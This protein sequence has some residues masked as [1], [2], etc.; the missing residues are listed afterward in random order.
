MPT[1]G[2]AVRVP[3]G[4]ATFI[5][6]GG[7]DVEIARLPEA[8]ALAPGAKVMIV[9]ENDDELGL[10]I[11]DPENG[12]LRVMATPADGFTAIDG[13]LVGWRVERALALRR[14]LGLPAPDAAYRLV[15]A[16]G[17]GLPGIACDVLGRYA[18]LWA[19]GEGL[20]GPARLVADA[21]RGFASLDGVV[22]KLRKRGGADGAI[23]EEIVGKEPPAEYEARERGVPFA[24]HARGATNVGLFTDMREHRV[25]LARFVGDKRVLNLFSYSGALGVAS[26]RAGAATVTNV[27]T[28]A[29]V[30]AWAQGNFRRSGLDD[31]K[32]WRFETGDAV[33]F[34][35]RAKK[36]RERYDVV[37]VDPPTFSTARGAAWTLERDYP[38]LIEQAIDVI[39]DG[40]VI[41]LAANSHVAGDG[42]L[43]KLAHKAARMARRTAVVLDVG[44]LPPDYPTSLAQPRDRYLQVVVLRV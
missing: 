15:N 4:A 29:G 37:L 2:A 41:W 18:V 3:E 1:P 42:S 13:A 31:E 27:D 8:M 25:G 40:G 43:L 30:H 38:A 26:A 22:V 10:A 36:D 32:R 6:G 9:D 5:A 39:P 33:R 28:S 11:A 35:A 34:L 16:A 24:I 19:Y 21:V 23:K 7:R 17:D 44:G 14:A 12:R 20:L